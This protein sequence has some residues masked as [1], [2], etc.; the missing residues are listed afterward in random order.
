MLRWI[1]LANEEELQLIKDYILFTILL[2]VLERDMRLMHAHRLKMADIY[3]EGLGRIQDAVSEQMRVIRRHFKK[4]GIRIYEEK[5]TSEGV[6]AKYLCRGYHQRMFLLWSYIRSEVR[7][8]LR[9]QLRNIR[10]GD[11][12]T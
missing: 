3:A 7:E 9:K 4:R 8:Y 5:R 1:P 6:E 12:S 10:F 2:D 11:G